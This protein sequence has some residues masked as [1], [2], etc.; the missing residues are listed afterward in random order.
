M[1][2]VSAHARAEEA[3][4]CLEEGRY[5]TRATQSR[6]ACPS[7]KRVAAGRLCLKL[8]A[9]MPLVLYALFAAQQPLM[10]HVELRVQAAEVSCLTPRHVWA[11]W[12]SWRVVSFHNVSLARPRLISGEGRVLS[13]ETST[14]CPGAPPRSVVRFDSVVIEHRTPPW[15]W[16]RTLALGGLRAACA[17]HM[18]DLFDGKL[19]C[20]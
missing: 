4:A 14:L 1:L 7:R 11:S 9:A 8:A 5:A 19:P 2:R 13:R 12:A 3:P 10:R 17:Q 16:R 20:D 15:P 18:L 6:G